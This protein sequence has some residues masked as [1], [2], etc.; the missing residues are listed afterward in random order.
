MIIYVL[1]SRDLYNIIDSH[2]VVAV[3][4]RRSAHISTRT[5]DV[6]MHTCMYDVLYSSMLCVFHTIM[7]LLSL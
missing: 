2:R 6:F 3:V 5:Y 1:A 4:I 7:I